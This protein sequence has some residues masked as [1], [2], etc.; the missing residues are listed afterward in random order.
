MFSKHRAHPKLLIYSSLRFIW[1][2]FELNLLKFQIMAKLS[3]FGPYKYYVYTYIVK[4]EKRQISLFQQKLSDFIFFYTKMTIVSRTIDPWGA[5]PR[6]RPLTAAAAEKRRQF[7]RFSKCFDFHN[8][9]AKMTV[10]SWAIDPW[11]A[12]P[13]P[14]PLTAAA[15]EKRRQ[16]ERF[17]KCFD[18]H[19]FNTK[20]TLEIRG[21]NVGCCDLTHDLLW[22]VMT[23]NDL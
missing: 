23:S 11:G 1:A 14:R 21:T 8:F 12:H 7:E 20:I 17:S 2:I 4:A 10:V 19:N 6:P 18:F 5:H 3:R 22:P 16:F 15:A 9:N 13:R